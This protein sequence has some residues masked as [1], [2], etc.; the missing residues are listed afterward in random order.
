M[1][2]YLRGDIFLKHFLSNGSQQQTNK[3]KTKTKQ[4]QKAVGAGRV[5]SKQITIECYHNY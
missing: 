1:A 2:Q 5:I 4:K 3:Q